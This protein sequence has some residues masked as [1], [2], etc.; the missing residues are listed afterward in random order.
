MFGEAPSARADLRSGTLYAV[1]SP[2]ETV[3]YGQ[4]CADQS[5]AFYRVRDVCTKSMAARI[6]ESVLPWLADVRGRQL[7]GQADQRVPAPSL[8]NTLSA[9][10]F[11]QGRR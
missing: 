9:E 5:F 1:A 6:V 2:D 3:F 7:D 11:Q 10:F 4:V 8:A